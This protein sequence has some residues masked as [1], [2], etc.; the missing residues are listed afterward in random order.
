MGRSQTLIYALGFG[1]FACGNADNQDLYRP[2]LPGFV[3]DHPSGVAGNDGF[4]A[5][6]GG[7]AGGEPEVPPNAV[8][9]GGGRSDGGRAGAGGSAGKGGAGGNAGMGGEPA[10]GRC[11]LD[12]PTPSCAAVTCA[13]CDPEPHNTWCRTHCQ[14][15]ID[16]VAEHPNC[17]TAADPLCLVRSPMGAANACTSVGEMAGSYGSKPTDQAKAYYLCMCR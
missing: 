16:C 6:G 4:S 8:G 7:T 10:P 12:A 15:I 14:A 2:T 11:E 17:S 3:S 13:A 1:V 5:G 9:G